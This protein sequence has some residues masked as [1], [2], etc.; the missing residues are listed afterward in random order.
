MLDAYLV[1]IMLLSRISNYT[2]FSIDLNN[3]SLHSNFQINTLKYAGAIASY[4]K[5]GVRKPS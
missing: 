4:E 5:M 2:V 3:R 1:M